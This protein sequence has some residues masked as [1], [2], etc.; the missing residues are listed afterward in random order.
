MN[1][2][3]LSYQVDICYLI[4]NPDEIY[5]KGCGYKTIEDYPEKRFFLF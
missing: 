2:Y 5:T 3:Q 1:L 4:D